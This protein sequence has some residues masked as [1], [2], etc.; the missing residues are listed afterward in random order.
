[1]LVGLGDLEGNAG[2]VAGVF[3]SP[4]FLLTRETNLFLDF[5]SQWRAI[6]FHLLTE[7]F[8]LE[9]RLNVVENWLSFYSEDEIMGDFS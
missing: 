8:Q 2:G 5:T 4:L 9:S 7:G 6:H 3:L 1:M